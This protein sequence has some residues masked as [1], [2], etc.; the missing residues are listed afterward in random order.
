M[1]RPSKSSKIGILSGVFDPVHVGHL[2][3]AYLA[4]ETVP[5]DSIWFIPTNVPPHKQKPQASYENRTQMLK[6]AL[7]IEPR[8]VVAELEGSSTPSYSFETLLKVRALIGEKP[9]FI[10]GSDEWENLHLWKHYDILVENA[11]FVVI[12][13]GSII[14]DRPD[15]TAIFTEKTPM[16]ISSTYIRQRCEEEKPIKLLV[17]EPV[18]SFIESHNLYKIPFYKGGE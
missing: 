11:I 16:N 1:I 8:F 3:M 14:T 18:Q 17:P 10:I 2:F 6:L 4:M 9:Y 12:P 13:R 15:A 5:L 7:Q